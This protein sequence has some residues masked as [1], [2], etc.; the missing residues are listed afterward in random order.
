M[1]GSPLSSL[2][3]AIGAGG[4]T[5]ALAQLAPATPRRRAA[6]V[7]HDGYAAL[8]AYQR[9]RP[10]LFVAGLAGFVSSGAALYL[11]RRRGVEA[12]GVWALAMAVSGGVAWVT[13]PGAAVPQA[14][15]PSGQTTPPGSTPAL[16]AVEAWLDRRAAALDRSEPGWEEQ[17]VRRVLG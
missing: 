15:V 17:A 6:V 5:S 11:R 9:A 12:W 4:G 13:R 8:D 1:P 10:A 2:I 3:Q 14:P 16:A 7:I